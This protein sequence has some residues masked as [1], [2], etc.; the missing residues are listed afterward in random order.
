[1]TF[2]LLLSFALLL[3]PSASA[4]VVPKA[5]PSAS[6]LA[7]ALGDEDP[8]SSKKFQVPNIDMDDMLSKLPDMNS[9]SSMD[10]ET[11]KDNLLDGSVGER[12]EAYAAAQLVLLLC[13]V[14]GGIPLVGDALM[15]LLGPCLMLAG[16]ATILLAI[17]DLGSN[18]SPWAVP[19]KGGKLIQDGIYAQLRHPQYAGILAALAGFSIITGSANRLLLT[20]VL[21]YA[22][23]LMAD[24]EEEELQKKFP[25]YGSYQE[26][27]RGK[28]FPDNLL[29]QLPWMK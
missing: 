23:N 22:F 20:A 8:S 24:F 12:G 26:N 21:F 13:I 11:L 3:A 19:P 2:K 29:K 28:F 5:R 15:V 25:S 18:L 6:R 4:F 16:G 9:L 17:K 7:S 10:F 14:G 1:M 27:V